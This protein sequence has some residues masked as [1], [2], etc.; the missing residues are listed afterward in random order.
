ML[1][2]LPLLS[3]VENRAAVHRV[4]LAMRINIFYS[5]ILDI[6]FSATEA[7]RGSVEADREP[8]MVLDWKIMRTIHKMYFHVVLLVVDAM[9]VNREST[10]WT[11]GKIREDYYWYWMNY[12]V[13]YFGLIA[14]STL[15]IIFMLSWIYVGTM[16]W[17]GLHISP[18]K[19]LSPR[20][21]SGKV[22]WKMKMTDKM[23]WIW[24]STIATQNFIVK[25]DTGNVAMEDLTLSVFLSNI[26]HLHLPS[27]ENRETPRK[28]AIFFLR[29]FFFILVSLSTEVILISF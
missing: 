27:S 11:L 13:P 10:G 3:M 24:V 17:Q 20:L 6:L 29:G 12:F 15:F 16:E 5:I 28:T 2:S 4:L 9:H 7:R 8:E 25:I 19:N 1:P 23:M 18:K 26:F 22:R 14:I 21:F